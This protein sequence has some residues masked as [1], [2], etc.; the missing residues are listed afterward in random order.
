MFIESDGASGGLTSCWSSRIV[1]FHEVIVRRYSITVL[2]P[3]VNNRSHFYVTNVYGPATWAGKE[4]FY[5]ELFQLRDNCKGKWVLCGDFNSTRCQEERKGK[6]WSSKATDMF[7]TLSMDLA[8]LDL[9]MINQ[10][11]TCPICKRTGLLLGSTDFSSQL[12][13]TRNFFSQRL[14]VCLEEY[15]ITVL[16]CYP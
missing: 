15:R 11:F 5:L 12:N 7:N 16:S 9:P 6:M 8:L 10:S 13:G 14:K 4:D 3:L 2:L 1:L